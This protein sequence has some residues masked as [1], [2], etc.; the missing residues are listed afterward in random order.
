[1]GFVRYGKRLYRVMGERATASAGAVVAHHSAPLGMVVRRLREAEQRAKNLGG[2]NAFA[3]TIIKRSGGAVELTAPWFRDD[4][5]PER[6]DENP[7][8]ILIR[9]RDAFA[10]VGLSRRA[11]YL[12]QDWMRQLPAAQLFAQ[13]PG[14]YQSMLARTLEY[15]LG[16]Q[17]GEDK[18]T[19]SLGTAL[20]ALATSDRIAGM[21][22]REKPRQPTDFISTFLAV[23][24][25]LAREGRTRTASREGREN[26][27]EEAVHA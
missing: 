9:L 5:K 18:F 7:M 1:K 20:A 16:R 24:E 6:L 13:R 15:Q 23:S 11:A 8:G 12:L 27:R 19:T 3:L 14:E 25:F 22:D 26:R 17:S 21:L 10:S 2:R 4:R